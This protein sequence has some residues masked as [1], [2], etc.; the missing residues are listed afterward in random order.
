MATKRKITIK[1]KVRDVEK[2]IKIEENVGSTVVENE[3]SD[4][5]NTDLNNVP[6]VEENVAEISEEVKKEVY[7]W[8]VGN[9]VVT[10]P[11]GRIIFEAKVSSVPMF[12]LPPDIRQYLINKG[13]GTN[14]WRKDKEWLERHWADMKMIERLKEF[15][16]GL[17]K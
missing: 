10:K 5:D 12:K 14:V 8:A 11:K 9:T 15:L 2:D 3:I 7:A 17:D 13:F 16:A 6:P 4:A 1:R